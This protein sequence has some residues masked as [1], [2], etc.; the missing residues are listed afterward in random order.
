MA[1]LLSLNIKLGQKE[2]KNVNLKALKKIVYYIR[3][4]DR[5]FPHPAPNTNIHT[6]TVMISGM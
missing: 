2:N 5:L 3:P 1:Y 6:H 4:H